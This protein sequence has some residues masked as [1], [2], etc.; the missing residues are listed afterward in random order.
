M[1]ETT[2][3]RH[4]ATRL[5]ITCHPSPT[6]LCARIGELVT[7]TLNANH[8]RL[9]VDDLHRLGFDPVV[10]QTEL[11]NYYREDC[12]P[13]D[14]AVLVEHLRAAEELIFV[15][16]IWMYGMP[17]ILKGYFDRVWRPHVSFEFDGDRIRPLLVGVRHL[18]MIASHGRGKAE[19]DLV[20]DAT[21]A[22]FSTSLPS[23]L[24]ELETNTK[25]DLYGLDAA[26][27]GGIERELENIRQHFAWGS[28][29]EMARHGQA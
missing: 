20:G 15:L 4:D 7:D 5:L 11:A 8:A 22:F 23:V 27:A 10:S 21:Q 16:P 17:A 24:P 28:S 12:I 29:P 3:V 6:N 9:I 26:D 13:S 25:F 1:R 18:T 19:C 14:I 2:R